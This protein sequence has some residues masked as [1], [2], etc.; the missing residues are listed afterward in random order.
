MSR[1]FKLIFLVGALMVLGRADAA[2][3]H[4]A[5]TDC[6]LPPPCSAEGGCY[7][8]RDTWGY[9]PTQWSTWPTDYGDAASESQGGRTNLPSVIVPKAAQEDKAAPA[10]S[11]PKPDDASMDSGGGTRELDLP[12][13]PPLPAQ[14]GPQGQGAPGQPFAPPQQPGGNQREDAPPGLPPLPGFG[15]PPGISPPPRPA[16]G[17]G[18]TSTRSRGADAPPPLP[19]DFAKLLPSDQRVQPSHRATQAEYL[20]GDAPPVYRPT[21]TPA[22]VVPASYGE[23]MR[24]IPGCSLWASPSELLFGG[25]ISRVVS[26]IRAV[27]GSQRLAVLASRIHGTLKPLA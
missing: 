18:Q 24:V 22:G 13:L 9:Y 19:M 26:I 3:P 16:G 21:P 23:S 7:P 25:A 20:Q 14:P 10:P 27:R 1:I 2:G 5:C 15:P 17:P 8:K 6:P 11:E 4:T 12:S